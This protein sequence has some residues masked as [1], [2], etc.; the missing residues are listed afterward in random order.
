LAKFD[1]MSEELIK[2]A[3]SKTTRNA[4]IR[5]GKC[6]GAGSSA[7]TSLRPAIAKTAHVSAR[8]AADELNRR[9][10]KTT[11]GKR[12]HAMQIIRLRDRLGL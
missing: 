11:S 1:M 6:R 9:D 3:D 7:T 4:M 8:D 5:M 2:I 10:V 12:W